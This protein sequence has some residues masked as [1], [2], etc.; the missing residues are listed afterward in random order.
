MNANVQNMFIPP[1][2]NIPALTGLHGLAAA[3][4]FLF[5]LLHGEGVP[6]VEYGYMGVDIFFVLSGFV[7]SHVYLRQG[8]LATAG[9]YLRFVAVRLTRIYPLHVFMLG[10]ML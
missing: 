7:L 1:R 6:V 10:V 2:K 9:G 3:W 5:H 8:D 4:V